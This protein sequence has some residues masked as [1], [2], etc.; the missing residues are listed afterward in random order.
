M[1]NLIL[2]L[3]LLILCSFSNEKLNGSWSIVS[4]K[5]NG[6]ELD[7]LHFDIMLLNDRYIDIFNDTMYVYHKYMNIEDS[8]IH[9]QKSTYSYKTTSNTEMSLS[10]GKHFSTATYILNSD[11]LCLI[12]TLG[13]TISTT[14]MV[15]RFN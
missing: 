8:V 1:K 14:K 10:D 5:V 11:T 12:M 7:T 3:S 9:T 13:G 4:D 15:R 2:I 6:I